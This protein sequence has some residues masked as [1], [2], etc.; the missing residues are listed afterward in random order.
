MKK[1]ILAILFSASLMICLAEEPS[2]EILQKDFKVSLEWLKQKPKTYARD[3]FIIQ[4]L[5]QDDV[6][7]EDAQTAYSMAKRK[8]GH[9]KKAYKKYRVISNDNLK[10]YKAS[11]SE[12]LSMSDTNCVALGLSLK[13]VSKLSDTKLEK[14]ITKLEDN[15]KYPTLK[16]DLNI[17]LAKD[18]GSE[19]LQYGMNKFFKFFFKLGYDFRVKN[20]DRY[21]SENFVNKLAKHKKFEL[22]VRYTMYDKKNLQELQKALLNVKTNQKLSANTLFLLG[23]NAINHEDEEKAFYFFEKSYNKAYLRRDK[24]KALFWSYLITQN[25]SFLY[26]LANSW[27]INLYSAYAKELLEFPLENI[28]YNIDTPNKATYYDIY[29]PF[30]WIEV[31]RDTKKNL[32]EQKLNK[33][34]E[35]FTSDLTKPHLAFVLNR[36]HRYKKHYYITPYKNIVKDFSSYET[37]LLY[38]IARQES[39]FI[40][41]S[42]SVST[43]LGVMQIMPFLSKDIAKRLNEEYNIYEQFNPQKNIQYGNYHLKNLAK[44]FDNNPLFIAYAYNGGAGYFRKQLKKGLFKRIDK[45]Y[46]PF[47]SMEMISYP[48]TKKYGKKVLTNYYIYNN[49]LN[50][51]DKIK[52]STIFRTLVWQN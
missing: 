26:K 17:L 10:C 34:K 51:Q 16:K 33:Y 6:S 48:E 28:V 43:A 30:S 13:E 9:I 24:D 3:F 49:Y 38:S 4:Y 21:Y 20:F 5:K 15:S 39:L 29:D 1:I 47:L 19:D 31:L 23:I 44:Q 52:L 41:S 46:E 50:P 14:F 18:I 11:I 27:D 2:S 32:D 25:N 35:L 37:T 40:P 12:L 42:I 8:N 36:F 7:L 45:K 22:F